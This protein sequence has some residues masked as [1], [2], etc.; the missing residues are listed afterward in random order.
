ML[1]LAVPIAYD[2][3]KWG[4][5]A[6][7]GY[8][9]LKAVADKANKFR[10]A[11]TLV[12]QTCGLC[13]ALLEPM[14][15]A[16]A[17]AVR[18]ASLRIVGPALKLAQATVA[19]CNALVQEPDDD[20]WQGWLQTGAEGVT[21]EARIRGLQESLTRAM[22]ALH[23]ALVA[24]S[25]SLEPRSHLAPFCFVRGAFLAAHETFVRMEMGRER[26]LRLCGGEL[27]RRGIRLASGGQRV[28]A[29]QQLS[30]SVRVSLQRGELRPDDEDEDE[31]DDED[32][33]EDD[34]DEGEAAGEARRAS[35]GGAGTDELTLRFDPAE[36]SDGGGGEEGEEGAEGASKAVVLAVEPGLRFRR[37]WARQLAEELASTH[38]DD[39]V[40]LVGAD[41][42]CC[43]LP[44]PPAPGPPGSPPPCAHT[45]GGRA[46]P[47]PT[48]GRRP[49]RSRRAR[50]HRFSRR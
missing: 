44:P 20:D 17:L 40:D 29:M 18:H 16:E 7:N 14:A 28:D 46:R 42:V 4:K 33:G 50:A 48:E 6:Y 8:K 39:F 49:P 23:L 35:G 38:A 34:G 3:I 15:V 36:P 24:V 22:T 47:S 32:D 41:A 25:V 21:N 37:L 12:R 30:I 31:D 45:H 9:V 26:R 1:S 5:R 43:A 19:Q 13:S 27:W 11:P 10:R 2:A